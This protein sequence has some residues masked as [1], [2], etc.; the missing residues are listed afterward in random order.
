MRIATLFGIVALTLL[1]MACT[2][3]ADSGGT[4]ASEESYYVSGYIQK[5]P[6]VLGSEVKI[7]ELDND[8]NPSGSLYLTQTTNDFGEFK[9]AGKLT[10]K[11]AEIIITGYYFDEI[12]GAL[13]GGP[14]TLRSIVSLKFERGDESG[15]A[16][17]KDN[18]G[19]TVVPANVNILTTLQNPRLKKLIQYGSSFMSAYDT[20]ASQVLTSFGISSAVSGEFSNLSIASNSAG[21]SELLA[22]SSIVLQVAHNLSTTSSEWTAKLSEAISAIG[23]DLELDG[24]MNSS[25][26]TA[27]I[28]AASANVDFGLIRTNLAQ[29]YNDLG[30]SVTIPDFS[31]H[32]TNPWS[33][34][35]TFADQ[36][37]G[38]ACVSNICYLL[39]PFTSFKKIDLETQVVTTLTALPFSHGYGYARLVVIGSKLYFVRYVGSSGNEM[40]E[41]DT[42]LGAW[43]QNASA[44]GN[45]QHAWSAVAFNNKVYVFGDNSTTSSEVFDPSTNQW[46]WITALS[47]ARL[48][49]TGVAY[50][51]KIYVGGRESLPVEIY[52]PQSGTYSTL[53]I[54]NST[55]SSAQYLQMITSYNSI[56]YAMTAE[57]LSYNKFWKYSASDD[58]WTQISVPTGYIDPRSAHIYNGKIYILGGDLYVYNPAKE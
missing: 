12:S 29:R 57:S 38:M 44:S 18:K 53:S 19:R 33:K 3:S 7:Q 48:Y 4:V 20:S 28:S 34:V 17:G 25:T 36:P 10:G 22:A 24:V 46:T 15:M 55:V 21:S 43:T 37:S 31:E 58:S 35:A 6:F 26:Y 8:L 39:G 9:F 11:Y 52:D 32:V 1:H 40:W 30:L 51:S 27:A 49:P 23:T 50:N 14:L 47:N 5:G 42:I 2:K 54:S 45:H 16:R 13:S 56:L 41:Y